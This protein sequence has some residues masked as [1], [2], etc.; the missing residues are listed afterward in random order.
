M[1][2][3]GREEKTSMTNQPLTLGSPLHE[4][5]VTYMRERMAMPDVE[6]DQEQNWIAGHLFTFASELLAALQEARGHEHEE[7]DHTRVDSQ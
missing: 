1:N 5:V 6:T 4:R 7:Q 3:H 2:D